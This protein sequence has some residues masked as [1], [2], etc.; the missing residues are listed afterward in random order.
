MGIW[1]RNN[2]EGESL[3]KR[4]APGSNQ[5]YLIT[6][7]MMLKG[8]IAQRGRHQVRQYGVSVEGSTRIVTSGDS[9]D[10]ATFDAL[11]AAKAIDPNLAIAS[12]SPRA[13]SEQ[14]VAE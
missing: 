5:R 6:F 3:S 8:N 12:Q 4:G 11:V 1:S 13:P 14:A 10:Q 2:V 9:V 7:E